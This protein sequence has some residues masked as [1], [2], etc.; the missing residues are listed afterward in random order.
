MNGQ[1]FMEVNLAHCFQLQRELD[2]FGDSVKTV[3]ILEAT[4]VVEDLAAD[5]EVGAAEMGSPQAVV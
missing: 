3:S 5:S 4:G 2:V 1:S